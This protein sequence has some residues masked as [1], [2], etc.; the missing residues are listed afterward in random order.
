M[1][2]GT[3]TILFV[4]TGNTCRSPMAEAVAQAALRARPGAEA[5]IRTF[6]AGVGAIDGAPMT[7]EAEAALRKVGV[8]PAPHRSV[9]LSA[10]MIEKADRVYTM[11][12]SHRER[13]VQMAP[14]QAEKILVLD[15]AGRD[16]PD[17]I[18]RSQ[19]VYDDTAR[20]LKQMVEQRLEE[21]LR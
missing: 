9:P 11:T 6:S 19:R 10:A 8:E 20:E 21:A 4:C 17:P 16:V 5:R 3:R 7:P 12:A 1:A 15:P 18:G 13:V 2:E 14:A